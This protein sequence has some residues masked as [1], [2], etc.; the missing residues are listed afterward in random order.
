MSMKRRREKMLLSSSR[1]AITFLLCMISNISSNTAEAR[2]NGISFQGQHQEEH[3][4]FSSAESNS[5]KCFETTE[6]LR[7]AV[8]RYKSYHDIDTDLM[9]MYGWPIDNWCVSHIEDFSSLFFRK[10]HFNEPLNSWDMS[11]S[12]D[13]SAMFMDC[14]EFNQ[15]LDHWNVK[16]VTNM[17][18]M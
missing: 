18:R 10:R 6:E 5:I 14:F 8:R 9:E 16:G 13:T 11:N 4:S 17:N 3:F 15:P 1:S 7:G 12:K 2:L